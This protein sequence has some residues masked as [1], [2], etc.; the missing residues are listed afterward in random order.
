LSTFG[1]ELGLGTF[2]LLLAQPVDR[3][4]MWRTK[5]TVLSGAMATV[6]GVWCVS[7]ALRSSDGS[8][9]LFPVGATSVLAAFTGG[10]FATLLLRQTVAA[11]WFTILI[12]GA[13]VCII[14][15][16]HGTAGMMY[17]A[18]GIYAVATFMLARWQFLRAQEVGWTGGIVALPGWRKQASTPDGQRLRRPLFALLY[19][20]LQLQQVVLA[21]MA[22]LFVLHLAVVALRMLGLAPVDGALRA[23]F[24]VFGGLWFLAPLLAGSASM[25]EERK[26]G[27][28]DA[29]LCL[30]VSRRV[31]FTV[32]LLLVL[33]LGGLLS[34][35]LLWAVEG[36]PSALRVRPEIG[37]LA[38]PFEPKALAALSGIFLAIAFVCFY[39]STLARNILQSLALAVVTGTGIAFIIVLAVDPPDIFGIRLW[40]GSV[41]HFVFWPILAAAFLWLG[42]RNFNSDGRNLW[43]HNLSVLAIALTFAIG[44][45]A[46]FY[47]FGHYYLDGLRLSWSS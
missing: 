38:I 30:P 11:L 31:Q 18:L 15:G 46:W 8:T 14:D 43:Q 29:L 6:F 3:G 10:L 24:V 16:L 7:C 42:W 44:F 2:A 20:E 47:N 40:E 36:I 34:P 1:R 5:L 26:L 39:A 17:A 45:T 33:A 35:L 12:P 37:E 23:A 22:V 32:K 4:Q 25:A 19:K 27:T 9:D 21:G 41:A 28:S 13:M